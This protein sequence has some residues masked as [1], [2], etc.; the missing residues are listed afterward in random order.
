[1]RK[2]VT[3]VLKNVK[4]NKMRVTNDGSVVVNLPDQG[5]NDEAKRVLAT[6]NLDTKIATTLQP[7]IMV[8]NVSDDEVEDE[9]VSFILAKNDFLSG[10]D[11]NDVKVVGKRKANYGNNYILK[12]TP[13]ARKAIHDHGDAIYTTYGRHR[14]SDRYHVR[15]CNYCQHYGHFEDKCD[16]KKKKEA[17]TCGKCAGAHE[18]NDCN[19]NFKKCCHCTK[20]KLDNKEHYAYQTICPTYKLNEKRLM[21]NTDHGY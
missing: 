1:M 8:H 4:I 12:C 5:S 20:N 6:K 2:E 10:L 11:E 19:A 21:E 16:K 14:I 7:K 9:L 3:N 18:T 13:R 17:P 15:I